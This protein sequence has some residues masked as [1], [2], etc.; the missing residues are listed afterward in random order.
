MARFVFHR[1]GLVCS[2]LEG[3]KGEGLIDY[4]S[5]LFLTAPRRTGKSTFLR[6]D[7]IPA[8][9][10][11][12]WE[13]VYVDLWSDLSADPG[14]LIESA[15]VGVMREYE[16][17]VKRTLQ[18]AGVQKLTVFK[19]EWNLEQPSRLPEGA[20][21][22][23]ALNLLYQACGR[24]VVLIVDEAQQALETTTGMNAMFAL[25][26]ARD[27]LNQGLSTPGLRL[28]FTGSSRDKLAH[29]VLNRQ[30]PFFGAQITPFP[31][32]GRDFVA[33]YT[34]N[35]NQKLATGNRFDANDMMQAFELVGRRPEQLAAIVQRVALDMGEAPQLGELLKANAAE[36]R[37]SAWGEYEA[38][39]DPLTPVQKAV[40][41]SMARASHGSKT[42]SP[43]KSDTLQQVGALAEEYGQRGA[44]PTKQTVQAAIEALRDKG[45]LWRSGR[46]TYAFEDTSM[47]DW[48]VT[49]QGQEGV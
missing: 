32:L 45:L 28:V 34:D 19:M 2:M 31:L 13:P 49:Q 9:V 25:K 37:E 16:G 30:Q 10:A 35:I 33:A 7:L 4:S 1:T 44:A 26:A 6:E 12:G 29:L 23:D 17:S 42:F 39:F 38:A 41:I 24:M 22:T 3:L 15:I 48:L 8:C 43:Y 5:G 11:A 47:L 20:T 18:D 36:M 27:F 14:R 46:G 21:L 40:L